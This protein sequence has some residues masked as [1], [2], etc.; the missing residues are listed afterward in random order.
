MPTLDLELVRILAIIIGFTFPAAHDNSVAV[1]V[2]GKLVFAAEEERYTRHKHSLGEPPFNSF[3]EALR[4][5]RKSG[6]DPGDVNGFAIN[7][8]SSLFPLGLRI[9]RMTEGVAQLRAVAPEIA[10][11]GGI[12]FIPGHILNWTYHK[13]DYTEIAELFIEKAYRRLGATFPANSKIISV[14]HH[15]AHAA[16]AYYFSGFSSS[17]VLTI[18]G[19]GERDSTVVWRVKEGEFEKLASVTVEDGSLGLLYEK[20]SERLHFDYLTGPGKVMGL[21]PYGREDKILRSRFDAL[22]H[23]EGTDL[24]YI[25]AD[26]FRLKSRA[27]SSGGILRMYGRIV[28]E[29]TKGID[30]DWNPKTKPKEST[31]SLAWHLQQFT[32]SVV[33]KT[34]RWAKEQAKENNIALAGGVALNAKANMKLHYAHIYDDLFIFP[35]SN[36]AGGAIGAAAYVHEHVFGEKMGRGRIEDTYWGPQYDDAL[37]KETVKRGKWNAE[38][39]NGEDL[40]KVADLV[41]KGHIIGVFQ[42]RAEMGPR[43]LGNRSIIADP[44]RA[45]TWT[46]VNDMKGREYWRPLAPSVL[47]EDKEIYFDKP[48]DHRFMALMFRMTTEGSERTPAVCHVD[49]TSRPQMVARETNPVWYNLIRTFKD[50]S[51]EGLLVNTS[52]NLAGEPMVET[53]LDAIKSFA[54]GGFD[55][56]F[57]QGWLICK[58]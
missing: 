43:A 33:E 45:N 14:E 38:Y 11:F 54:V 15:L 21:A 46:R 58:H 18:D 39:L 6:I 1:V 50:A 32:E 29:L 51:G 17:I 36:D 40:S 56:L 30:L 8:V 13:F 42:G 23:V 12:R 4:F 47:E 31:A 16:S 44:T 3:L 49:A 20:L 7:W 53:P 41:S 37:I 19:A 27:G 2:D 35:V 28:D 22:V 57:L 25:F 55:D 5:L 52:F 10:L 9:P 24:P 26:E 48:V 34:A